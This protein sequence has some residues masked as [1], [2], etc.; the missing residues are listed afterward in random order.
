MLILN[1][2]CSAGTIDP[3]INDS[4]YI[5]Y[6]KKHECIFQ[7]VGKTN[8]GD[9]KN[10]EYKASCVLIDPK[11][12]ITAAHVIEGS[13]D[14]YI[15]SGDKKVK[16]ILS[17]YPNEYNPDTFSNYD[18]CICLLEDPINID[19]YP[20][21]YDKN[22]ERGK[23]CSISGYG[24]T[25]NFIN[26]VTKYDNKKRAGSN[27]IDGLINNEILFCSVND[28]KNKTSL[29]FLIATGDSGGGLFIEQ[30]LAGINSCIM[31][32]DGNLNSDISDWSVHTRV[33]SH[34]HWIEKTIKFLHLLEEKNNA[35]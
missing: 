10:I 2:D 16:I 19:F 20:K 13:T 32:D 31:S 4:K 34:K 14:H 25:G 12:A 1:I 27:I 35:K 3:E 6:G 30:K 7:I 26:G 28:K 15:L 5:E 23:I 9:K 17:I 22:D 29:E 21:L 8:I 18:I 24:A 33:S 11:I